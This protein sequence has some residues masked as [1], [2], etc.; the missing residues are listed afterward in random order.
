[1]TLR[2][3][4]LWGVRVL[5]GLTAVALL[6]LMAIVLV[7][8]I[9]RNGWNQPLPWASEVL[10]IVLAASVFLFLPVLAIRG[11]HVTV[12][13]IELPAMARMQQVLSGLIGFILFGSVT[14]ALARH[15]TRVAEFDEVTP[16]L[17]IPLPWIFGALT[18][19]AAL[20]SVL[21]LAWSVCHLWRGCTPLAEAAKPE[22]LL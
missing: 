19:L 22:E 7:D 1:M 11:G 17:S 10:E 12:D 16:L 6:A 4:T 13:L 9:G 21:S 18:A 2:S 15:T 3:I 8:V 5:E 14:W 20:T